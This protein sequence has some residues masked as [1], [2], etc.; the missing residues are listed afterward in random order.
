M[1]EYGC[2][3]PHMSDGEDGIQKLPLLPVVIPYGHT[4]SECHITIVLIIYTS[5]S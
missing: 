2:D 1:I 3:L 5:N 4:I